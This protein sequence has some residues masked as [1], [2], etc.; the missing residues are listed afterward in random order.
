M[1]SAELRAFRSAQRLFKI[2]TDVCSKVTP[3]KSIYLQ[4]VVVK[5]ERLIKTRKQN[6]RRLTMRCRC[7]LMPLQNSRQNYA[8]GDHAKAQIPLGPISP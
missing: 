7:Q 3:V 8:T 2:T 4:N 6:R 5:Q 1:I